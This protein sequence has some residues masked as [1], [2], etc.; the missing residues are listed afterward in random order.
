MEHKGATIW[1]TGLS[2]AG[3]STVANILAKRLREQGAEVEILDGDI[4]RTNLSK[5]LGFS[6]K[7]RDINIRRIGFVCSLLSRHGVIVLAAA[8]SPYRR[9]RR[10]M[11]ATTTNFVEVHTHCDLDILVQRDVKGLY[12]KAL[13]G[14]ISNFTGVSDPYEVPENPEVR[15][16]SGAETPEESAGLVWDYLLKS[17]IISP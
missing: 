12:K 10:E 9:L 2:G 3:K 14:E 4:I 16:D 1:L 8:I 13:A 17:G 15:T 5:G 7:D 6:K 11:R